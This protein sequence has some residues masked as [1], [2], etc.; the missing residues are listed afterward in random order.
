MRKAK[1]LIFHV[2]FLD[3]LRTV[4]SKSSRERTKTAR[5]LVT[6]DVQYHLDDTEQVGKS[7]NVVGLRN[8]L[9]NLDRTNKIFRIRSIL[10]CTLMKT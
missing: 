3:E 7:R 9:S 4:S 10:R 1:R 8:H 5:K 2:I 6:E